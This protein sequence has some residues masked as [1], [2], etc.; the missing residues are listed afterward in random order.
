MFP[1]ILRSPPRNPKISLSH[2]LMT[3]SQPEKDKS[4]ILM[5][6]SL[7]TLNYK[8]MYKEY[9]KKSNVTEKWKV[10]WVC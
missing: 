4:M 5:S 6:F 7:M 8:V 9:L 1:V 3:W 2:Q 10:C